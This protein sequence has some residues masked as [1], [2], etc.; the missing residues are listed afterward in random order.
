MSNLQTQHIISSQSYSCVDNRNSTALVIITLKPIINEKVSYHFCQVI[1]I[2]F[3]TTKSGSVCETQN[4]EAIIYIILTGALA[5]PEKGQTTPRLTTT[6]LGG[7]KGVEIFFH[8][9]N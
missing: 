6:V 9:R 3:A 1:L 4:L 8:T 7:S 2:I 5:T